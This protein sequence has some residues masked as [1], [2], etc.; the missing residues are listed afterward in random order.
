MYHILLGVIFL[1]QACLGEGDFYSFKLD[2]TRGA[3]CN[4]IVATPKRSGSITLFVK[5]IATTDESI[6]EGLQFPVLIF[7]YS[8]ILNYANLPTI[9]KYYKDFPDSKANLYKDLVDFENLKFSLLTFRDAEID[10]SLIL[11]SYITLDGS[12]G[13]D[14]EHVD[15]TLDITTSGIYCIYIAPPIEG[16]ISLSLPVKFTNGNGYLSAL[17]YMAYSQQKY[18]AIVGTLIF[19]YLFYYILRFKVGKDF[20][21]MDTI[22]IISKAVIFFALLPFILCTILQLVFGFLE[23]NFSFNAFH[24]YFFKLLKLVGVWL[25]LTFSSFISF[26]ILLFCM[27]YGV[28]YY[29]EANSRNYRILPEKQRK[30]AFGLLISDFAISTLCVLFSIAGFEGASR[31]G[32]PKA[33]YPYLVDDDAI[34]LPSPYVLGG[35]LLQSIYTLTYGLNF[36]FPTIWYGMSIYHYFQTKKVISKFPPIPN[37]ES[38]SNEKIISSFRKSILVIFVLPSVVMTI[39]LGVLMVDLTKR[40]E[41]ING[42]IYADNADRPK[43]LELAIAMLL[44]AF[45]L[46]SS[47]MLPLLWS[48]AASFFLKIVCLF[49]IW[50]KDNNG[51]VVDGTNSE[52]YGEVSQ[53]EVDSEE[54]EQVEA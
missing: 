24:G 15:L 43:V 45:Q 16:V 41:P 30:L 53:F 49:Y 42:K 35:G 32:G 48:A 17:N 52:A 39:L 26:L 34:F 51:L 31:S 29:H 37:G 2:D 19:G 36:S 10:E 3:V 54:D 9:E 38:D 27:G 22:S 33:A 13:D 4:Y 7:K 50:I 1:I 12:E 18:F 21:S 8:E 47:T 40:M 44:T 6:I 25:N 14:L 46:S 5:D 28:V 23:N 20:K 11:N